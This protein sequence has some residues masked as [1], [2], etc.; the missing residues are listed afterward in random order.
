MPIAVP[1]TGHGATFAH[2]SFAA[3]FLSFSASEQ[4]RA[5]L[6][7]SHL[8]T[9]AYRQFTPGDLIDAGSFTATFFTDVNNFSMYDGSG[10]A[11][12][13]P[14]WIAAGIT[15]GT[16]MPPIDGD[17]V[18]TTITLPKAAPGS[19]S[20]AKIVGSAYF[21]SVS[22]PEIATETLMQQTAVLKWA[23]GPALAPE[24]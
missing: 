11:D 17:A 16:G 9:F 6:D 21:N 19:A 3:L 10:A 5:D 13:V 15:E 23:D 2:G 18:T 7:K 4:S 12:L 24:A 14:V 20:G 22:L 8:G 1:I